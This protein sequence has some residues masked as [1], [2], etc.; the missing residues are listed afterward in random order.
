M[1][2]VTIEA[3]FHFCQ[4]RIDEF[5][6]ATPGYFLFNVAAGT[7]L[8]VQKQLWTIFISGRNLTNTKYFDHLS[9]LKEV[10]IYNA[11]WNLTFG[12]HIPF[13]IYTKRE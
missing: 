9:R 7:S 11:G 5:E 12:I 13:G 6:T 8:R 2:Y 4:E 3:E 10:G 1:P